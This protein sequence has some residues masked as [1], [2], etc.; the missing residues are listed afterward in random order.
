MAKSKQKKQLILAV[1]RGD[2]AAFEE[3]FKTYQ[4]LLYKHLIYLSRDENL[5]HDL[6]QDVFFKIWDQKERL[7]PNLSFW[8]YIVRMGTNFYK[9]YFRH[10]QIKQKHLEPLQNHLRSHNPTPEN[11][12]HHQELME[13]FHKIIQN[14]LP[15][16]CQ[17]IFILSRIEGYS[18]QE[19]ANELNITKR[20][21]ENQLY[22]AL[23]ILRKK[24]KNFL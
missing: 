6:V 22:H 5:T 7:N 18:S 24:C 12:F 20:T 14:H 1:K 9:D 3:L 4:P 10:Q 15:P 23:K 19:I 21:V 17:T 2:I 13:Q 8:A 16:K 11:G